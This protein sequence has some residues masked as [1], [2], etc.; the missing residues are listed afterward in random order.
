MS[1][2]L[3]SVKKMRIL[4]SPVAC[5]RC[6]VCQLSILA[7]VCLCL[8][9]PDPL[10]VAVAA[11]ASADT[12]SADTNSADT[13]SA[14]ASVATA[15]LEQKGLRK[16]GS[17]FAISDEAEVRRRLRAAELLK[18]KLRDTG[19][20]YAARAQQVEQKRKLIINYLQQ[21]REL[22]A[23]LAANTSVRTHNR[24]VTS[25][26]ELG[27]RINLMQ[28]D[29]RDEQAAKTAR[30]A[31]ETLQSQYVEQI[32]KT[33]E[34]YD[35]VAQ[36]YADLKADAE[37]AEAIAAFNKAG[38]KSC[39]LGPGRTYASLGRK[40]KKIEDTILSESIDLRKDGGSLWFVPVVFNDGKMQRMA[41]DTGASIIS[42]PWSM[43]AAIDM[44]PTAG[45]PTMQVQMA[46]GGVVTATRKIASKVRVG[47]FT[48]ENVECAVMPR[49]L[50]EA[51]PLLGLSF[52]KHFTFKI[53]TA[54]AK[55]IMSK[56]EPLEKPSQ[57][58]GKRKTR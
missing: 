43:A 17:Y 4:F 15:A 5:D 39:Q 1:V 27:D 52:L 44:S 14:D 6:V 46:D 2:V 24:L 11:A 53:D 7:S 31:H 18:K 57:S 56:V 29:D 49:E 28:H 47:K 40:L 23:R 50:T 10:V 38:K 8:L 26:N 42:L 51:A 16:M 58:R 12:N 21:R 30:A 19:R 34:L 37:V 20:E 54:N 22:R 35:R 41:I 3:D 55:L 9:L 13:N 36:K 48:V 32:L 33:R 45:D 25:L